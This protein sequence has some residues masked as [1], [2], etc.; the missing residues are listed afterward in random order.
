MPTPAEL[1]ALADRTE[2]YLT[3][4]LLPFWMERSP[5]P[6]Y[7]GFLSY[8]DARG[9]PTGETT[10]TFL[11]Q[12]RMLYTMASAHRAGY[13]GGRCADLARMGA[14]FLLDHYWDH[15]HEGW[16]WIADRAGR[17]TVTAK[18]G[19]GQWFAL[20]ALSEYALATGDAEGREAALRT[21]AAICRHM[22][23]TAHGGYWEIMREN[24]QP[25]A[26]G[27]R[28]GDRKSFDVHMHAM[29]ALTTF[30]ELTHHPTHRRR[31]LEAIELIR[32]RMLHREFGAGYMQFSADWT[33]LPAIMFD[34]EWGS[35]KEPE[36]GARP[37]LQTSYGHNAEF[38]W[39]L[40]HAA[41][42]LGQDRRTHADL[43]GRI[44]GHCLRHGI[45]DEYGGV[46]LEG[47]MD[48]QATDTDKQ[49]WQQAE[50]MVALLGAY[51][52]LGEKAY[53]RAFRRTYD[54]V[55]ERLVNVEA[56]GEWIALAARDGT[57]IWGY[58]GHAWKISYHTVR[59]TIQVT[60]RLRRLAGEGG[61]VVERDETAK[62][63]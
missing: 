52:L 35:D 54:F 9:R 13:G 46:Y 11:M 7:G 58:L 50:V 33:P 27:R 28:G 22:A 43:I 25:E 53:W 48:G 32:T 37:L 12:V 10:K 3:G 2:E 40:L 17:P 14:R 18:V 47:P 36:G 31:L 56:G 51:A 4:T 19:Y 5:D 16:I 55:F 42:V 24:W 8:F 6:E 62:V 1:T 63:S 61:G 15:E 49:F 34:V 57:P 23:D 30:Y 41:D 60:R 59:G 39:L 21:Y 29:E 44:M 45:D 38:A 20:Y 26:P